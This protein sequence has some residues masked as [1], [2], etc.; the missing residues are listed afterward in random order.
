MDS[1]SFH[2]DFEAFLDAT[3]SARELSERDRDYVDLKQWTAK[4]EQTL[5][6]RGQAPVVFDYTR[7]QVD[8]FLGM[9]RDTR[10]DPKAYP[11]TKEHDEDADSVTYAIRYVTEEAD[12]DQVCSEVFE[13]MLVEGYAAAIIEAKKRRDDYEITIRGIKWDRFYYDPHS[14]ARDFSDAAY[15]GIVIWMHKDQAK[16]RYPDK[17]A[18]IAAKMQSED[19]TITFDDRPIWFDR[20]N[21][22]VR[23]CEHYYLEKGVWHKCE[24]A[25][26]LQLTEP[27]KVGYKDEDDEPICPIEGV[28]A[29]VDRD[30]NRYGYVRRLID[31]QREINHRRSKALF[32]ASANQVIYE[33]GSI[34]DAVDFRDELKKPDGMAK[35][36]PG[37]L[38]DGAMQINPGRDLASGQLQMYQDAVLKIDKTGS[39]AA[40][41]GDVE[42]MSGRAIQRLQHGGSIQVGPI[43][44]ALRGWK[45]R[46]YRQIWWRVR[47]FWDEEKWIRVTDDENN[48]QFVGL[49]Q[50]MTVAEV[51][52][53]KAEKGD[54]QAAQV[55]Q[56]MMQQQDPRLGQVAKTRNEVAKLDVDI[57]LDESPD[58]ATTQEEQFR[59]LT[60]LLKV[61]GPQAVPFKSMI[62]L[63][64]LRGKDRVLESIEGDDQAKAMQQQI[65]EQQQQMQQLIQQL[66]MQGMELDNLGKQAKAERDQAEADKTRAETAET[67]ASMQQTQMENELL[68]RFPDLTPNV[69]I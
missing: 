11:R 16:Q 1:V 39:N 54:Q 60:E 12:F 7:E 50:P 24:F 2:K 55:L 42:G 57:I 53:E 47:Q 68:A 27:E 37:A 36:N 38:T 18:D 6:A 67:V 3:Q 13:G 4:E 32:S 20:G 49:N 43:F 46:V 45:R 66:Q 61:Y 35:V 10:Q 5:L 17:E 22:R 25:G 33:D 28:S 14:R 40:M 63:S 48:L 23:V 64:S 31:P 26:D 65:A 52:Q 19:G 8:Y 58:M 41:Q 59:M 69:N 21:D 44:D 9:E 30:N 15:M 29:F 51:L 56:M 34:A 62:E